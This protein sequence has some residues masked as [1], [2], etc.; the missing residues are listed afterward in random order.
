MAVWERDSDDREVHLLDFCSA[1]ITTLD[2][3]YDSTSGA[4]WNLKFYS[5]HLSG[6]RSGWVSKLAAFQ[7]YRSLNSCKAI[8]CLVASE[9]W[10]NKVP[11]YNLLHELEKAN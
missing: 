7:V 2:N 10:I 9:D 11:H 6:L 8:D 1:V 4:Q 3:V 5:S